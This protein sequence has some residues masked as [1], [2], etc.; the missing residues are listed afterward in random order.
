[1]FCS[2]SL[3]VSFGYTGFADFL[4]VKTAQWG[5]NGRNGGIN[6]RVEHAG[7]DNGD[8]ISTMRTSLR[9][10]HAAR[11]M[12]RGPSIWTRDGLRGLALSA[13]I[14]PMQRPSLCT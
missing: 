4:M 7:D 6:S 13:I 14:P 1:M 8:R 12:A 9:A 11:K 10:L 3:L 5:R 2:F